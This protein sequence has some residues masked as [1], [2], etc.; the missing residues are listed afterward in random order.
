MDKNLVK[1]FVKEYKKWRNK[2]TEPTVGGS[3]TPKTIQEYF[4]K[5]NKK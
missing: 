3:K 1:H 4:E 2:E 5:K